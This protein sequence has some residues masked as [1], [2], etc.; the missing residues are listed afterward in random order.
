MACPAIPTCGLA[1]AEAERA[2]PG[3][4]R[5]LA[6]LLDEVGLAMSASAFA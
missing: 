2:L 1:V 3:L 5:Q 6:T 4:I